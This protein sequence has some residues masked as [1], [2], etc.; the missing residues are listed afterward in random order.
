MRF[1]ACHSSPTGRGKGLKIPT[2]IGSNPLCGTKFEE[3]SKMTQKKPKYGKATLLIELRWET[4]KNRYGPAAATVMNALGTL[5]P[6]AEV[7]E[8][9]WVTKYKYPRKKA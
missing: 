1:F 3:R 6:H 2:G 7:T 4:R 5:V 9:S 8:W